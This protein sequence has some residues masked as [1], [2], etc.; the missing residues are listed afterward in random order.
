MNTTCT[1][2]ISTYNW[3]AA[4]NICLNSVLHQTRM[5]DEIIIA[6]DGS[7]TETKKLVESFI[8][9]F[10]NK[11]VHIWQPDDGYRLS[12]IRNKA[13]AAAS[14]DYIIQIDGDLIL[15]RKFVEDHMHFAKKNSFVSGT[16]VNIKE[17]RTAALINGSGLPAVT[18]TNKGIEKRYNAFRFPLLRNMYPA[19]SN[20]KNA[21]RYVLGCNMAFWK[22]DLQEVNGYNEEFTGWGKEDNDLAVRLLNA[23]KQ[24]R[25]LKFGGIVFHLWHKEAAKGRLSLNEKLFNES[26]KNNVTF[27]KAGINRH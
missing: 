9:L 18:F 24:L 16:R 5:P 20:S 23:G 2:V 19:V 1:L 4:L 25:F 6:D 15:H 7:Q 26:L 10:N 3:P 8:P 21:Y 11:A 14:C 13:F 27:V 12:L 17:Q 22:K